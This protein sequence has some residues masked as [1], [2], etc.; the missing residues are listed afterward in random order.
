MRQ[1]QQVAHINR[2][3]TPTTCPPVTTDWPDPTAGTTIDLDNRPEF[4]GGA[5]KQRYSIRRESPARETHTED[6]KQWWENFRNVSDKKFHAVI[7][8]IVMFF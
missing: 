4:L 1:E 2:K 8:Q 7:S 3:I 5:C 6:V